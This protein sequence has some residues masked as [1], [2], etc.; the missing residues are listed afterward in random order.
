MNA[1]S[2][3]L[4]PL[5]VIYERQQLDMAVPS[6]VAVADLLPA[7]VNSLGRLSVSTATD[8][9]A[10]VTQSGRKLDQALTLAEQDVAAGAVLTLV[11]AQASTT[12][13][14][15]DD[16]TEAI[17]RSLDSS[18]KPWQRGDSVQLSA[19]CAVGLLLVATALVGWG[20]MPPLLTSAAC[21][22]GAVL[23]T[24]T[25]L[26]VGKTQASPG[27]AI[28]LA[29]VAPV[30]LAVAGR[31]ASGFFAIDQEISFAG[32]GFLLGAVAV[33]V[34]PAAVRT[35]AVAPLTVGLVAVVYG[36]AT[37]FFGATPQR[38]GATLIAVLTIMTLMA[39]WVGLASMP[40]RI[41]ALSATNTQRVDPTTLDRQVRG[42]IGLVLSLRIA[43]GV[44]TLA[45]IPV[46]AT[47]VPG[48]ALVVVVG[49]ALM[50]GS[51]SLYGRAEALIG[52]ITGILAVVVCA[53]MA[54][55]G[56]PAVLPWTIA[57][58]VVVAVLVL[59][60]NVISVK[61]RPGLARLADTVQI[62]AL[63]AILPTTAL[64]W[65]LV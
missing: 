45:L 4:T 14:R 22:I 1:R 46:T 47:T 10:L 41:A 44:A 26:V 60:N 16:L 20:G 56:N 43:A 15:Y 63:V 57:A 52:L 59:I 61:L 23:V 24:L 38:T 8:G 39:P 3:E 6:V 18:S 48:A 35:C 55:I 53:L 17:G 2:A 62:V 54:T 50:L 37:G 28:A 64:V 5:S 7:M 51:R 33:F 31:A 29:L 27:G 34:L 40:A 19:Y 36:F 9:F 49:L 11:P 21:V 42:G 32:L 13:T 12:S 58:S 65:G 25:A 30:M